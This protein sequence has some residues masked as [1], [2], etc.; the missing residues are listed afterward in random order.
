MR[1]P[2]RAG[3]AVVPG[4]VVE[5]RNLRESIV[6]DPQPRA[7]LRREAGH[8]IVPIIIKRPARR[9]VACVHLVCCTRTFAVSPCASGGVKKGGVETTTDFPHP[10]HQ[11]L[12]VGGKDPKHC[13]R[14]KASPIGVSGCNR[15]NLPGI[16]AT[17]LTETKYLLASSSRSDGG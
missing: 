4:K 6:G 8:E 16:L 10:R 9:T 3:R 11:P 15:R 12:T 5:A 13:N 2:S 7:S 17:G 14:I 1:A